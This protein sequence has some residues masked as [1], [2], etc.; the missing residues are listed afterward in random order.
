MTYNFYA[1]VTMII[2]PHD[3]DE[4][5]IPDDYDEDDEAEQEN[6]P[7]LH[8]CP[9]CGNPYLRACSDQSRCR[10]CGIHEDNIPRWVFRLNEA[11]D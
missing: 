2:N 9:T 4:A 7:T 10:I 6:L 5:F 1:P 3:C 8:F 11:H